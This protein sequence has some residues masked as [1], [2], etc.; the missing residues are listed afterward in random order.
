MEGITEQI[1]RAK[2]HQVGIDLDECDDMQILTT[3]FNALHLADELEINK[4]SSERGYHFILRF[5]EPL[6][7]EDRMNIR[8]YLGDCPGRLYFSEIRGG[9][10]ILFNMKTQGGNWV[11]RREIDSGTLINPY[12]S[13][14]WPGKRKDRNMRVH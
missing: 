6:S 8:Y 2:S 11:K 1:T 13:R 14:K 9:D 5:N 3:Y 12:N 7:V 10:D 4:S